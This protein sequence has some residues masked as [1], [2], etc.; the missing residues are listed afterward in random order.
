MSEEAQTQVEMKDEE[1]KSVTPS[2]AASKIVGLDASGKKI[3]DI[4]TLWTE[5]QYQQ[6]YTKADDYWKTQEA[7]VKGGLY[8]CQQQQQQQALVSLFCFVFSSKK[9]KKNSD[10]WF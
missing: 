3:E 7:S 9:Q 2:G 5:E 1:V 6:Y 10:G 4:G 8:H